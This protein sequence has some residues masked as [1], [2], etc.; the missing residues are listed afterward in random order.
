VYL[1]SCGHICSM[2]RAT[3]RFNIL[4]HFSRCFTSQ[5]LLRLHLCLLDSN[6]IWLTFFKSL[7]DADLHQMSP[8]NFGCSLFQGSVGKSWAAPLMKEPFPNLWGSED[9]TVWFWSTGKY[10]WQFFCSFIA[11]NRMVENAFLTSTFTL[12]EFGRCFWNGGIVRLWYSSSEDTKQQWELS[13]RVSSKVNDTLMGNRQFW[14]WCYS[15][16]EKM[17]L[18]VL[19][20]EILPRIQFILKVFFFLPLCYI[21]IVSYYGSAMTLSFMVLHW[22]C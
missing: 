20:L 7:M 11:P 22:E 3:A 21:A 18:L 16:Q 19:S 13:L 4:R 15:V 14:R 1:P 10:Y 2:S 17:L 5:K 8:Y 6:T 9:P 12:G